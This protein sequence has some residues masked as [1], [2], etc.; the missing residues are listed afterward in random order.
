MASITNNSN[1]DIVERNIE[2]K[3]YTIKAGETLEGVLNR[4]AKELG[5]VY[6]FLDVS[7]SLEEK[8]TEP[9]DTIEVED[10]PVTEDAPVE[11]VTSNEE[12]PAV[13]AEEPAPEETEV[14]DKPKRTRSKK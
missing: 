8:V 10:A 4:H 5:I 12:L 6:G 2:G 13:T 11:E 9:A 1:V 7:L 14:E 3:F